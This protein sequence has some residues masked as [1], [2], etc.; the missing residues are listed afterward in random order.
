MTL[1]GPAPR[2]NDRIEHELNLLWEAVRELSRS[3]LHNASIS[4]GGLLIRDDGALEVVTSTGVYV[5]YSRRALDGKREFGVVRDNGT[6]VIRTFAVSGE[7]AWALH[8]NQNGIV[9]S[10][11][12]AAGQGIARPSISMPTRRVRFDGLPN[13]DNGTFDAVLDSGFF[14]KQHPMAYV[15]LVHCSSTSGTTGEARLML[16]GVQVGST[17]TV[18]F[19]VTY[20]NVGPFAVPGSHMSQHRLVLECRRTGGAGRVGADMTIRGEQ[21]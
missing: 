14:Y 18:G 20:V 9:F 3:T 10:D 15:Q 1:P 4:G 11:D 21:S 12:A 16:D 17:I 19:A 2:P 6:Y 8:D 13:T 7:Q 5:L